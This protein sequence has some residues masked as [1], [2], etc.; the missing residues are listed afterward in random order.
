MGLNH[1]PVAASELRHTYPYGSHDRV[2][3][4][5]TAEEMTA[6]IADIFTAHP[7]CRRIVV[8]VPTGDTEAISACEQAGLRYVLDVEQRDGQELSLMVA[9]QGWVAAINENIEG[10]DLS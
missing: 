2:L 1:H 7:Q 8:P 4:Q 6:A 5:G 3:A 9:E 10:L